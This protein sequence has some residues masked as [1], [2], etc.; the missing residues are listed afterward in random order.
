MRIRTPILPLTLLGL[1]AGPAWGQQPTGRAIMERYKEQDYTNDQTSQLRM[2]LVRSSGGKRERTLTY[3]TKTDAE[4]NRKMLI[5]F[6]APADIAKT[7]FLAIEHSDRE[8]DR[9]LYLPSL[10]KTR[11]IAGADKTDDFVG[12]EFTY[13]D[14][15]SEKL[16]LHEYERLGTET[17]EGVEAWVVAAV[18][19]DSKK[20]EETGYSRRE[21]WVS[22]DHYVIVQAKYYDKDGA[23][24]KRFG[25]SDIRQV[26]GSEKRRAYYMTMKDVRSGDQTVLETLELTIDGGVPNDFFSERYL[27]R[28]R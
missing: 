19:N 17:V 3:V 5:R 7:G 20:I 11:R 4:G 9:W 18:P 6:T 8:D 28:G 26:P 10:R 15:E 21:L 16:D 1:W 23:Y 24:V 2:T 12:S 27:K 13:E 22:S 25:A 14:L